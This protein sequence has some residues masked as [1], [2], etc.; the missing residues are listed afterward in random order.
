VR[1]FVAHDFDLKYLIRATTGSQTY[2]RSSRQ[3]HPRQAEP[4]LFARTASRALTAEQ[5][6]DSLILATGYRPD[7]IPGG[8]SREMS[9][10]AVFL[11]AFE[12]PSNQ[13]VDFQASIQQALMMMNS[14]LTDEATSPTYSETLG[15]PPLCMGASAV[16]NSEGRLAF[17]AALGAAP[18]GPAPDVRTPVRYCLL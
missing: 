8:A 5:L 7:P 9:R 12:D 10:R 4:R 1:Q 17:R 6:Y 3:T 14:K 18:V 16:W 2:Q 15:A 13:P 11:A